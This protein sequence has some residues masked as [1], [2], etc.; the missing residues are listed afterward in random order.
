[1][2]QERVDKKERA[3]RRGGGSGEGEKGGGERG[4]KRVDFT[5][6]YDEMPGWT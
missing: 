2:I 3:G 1:M 6:G 5:D 4:M